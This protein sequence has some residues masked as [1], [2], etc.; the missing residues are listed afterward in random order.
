MSDPR[1]VAVV[2]VDGAGKTTQARLL[3]ERLRAG[4]RRAVLTGGEQVK[5]VRAALD[6][7]AI[8]GGRPTHEARLGAEGAYVAWA[9]ARA[10]ALRA[11]LD[12]ARDTGAD[13][14]CDRYAACLYATDALH[15][16]G[17]GELLR[18]LLAFA[19]P[20]AVTIY[21]DLP[22]EEAAARTRARGAEPETAE[23]LAAYDRAYRAL[24]EFAGFTVVDARGSV[25]EVRARVALAAGV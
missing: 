25:D 11:G 1:I 19:P 20:P 9:V 24:P 16:A 7:W 5:A 15:G 12:A 14:V 3:A 4:G 17:H 6:A 23:T 22:A 8:A 2:G 18:R 10:A 21:L 13:L